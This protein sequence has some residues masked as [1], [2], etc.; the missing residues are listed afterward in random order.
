MSHDGL[1]PFLLDLQEISGGVIPVDRLMREALYHPDYGYYSKNIRTVGRRGDFATSASLGRI[2]GQA[3]AGWIQAQMALGMGN[4]VIEVGAGSGAMA[5]TV[6]DSLSFWNRLRVRYHIVESS[7]VLQEE[8]MI[9][10]RGRR[11]HW[12]D[13]LGEAL[14]AVSGR[15]IVFSNELIDAFPCRVFERRDG[16]WYEVAIRIDGGQLAEVLVT[17]D[18][19]PSASALEMD[20]PDT[21]RVEVHTAAGEWLASWAAHAKQVEMLTIDYGGLVD[22]LYHRR[23]RGTLRAYFHQQRFDGAAVFHRFGKQDITAD[24]NFSDLQSWGERLGWKTRK[25]QTQG[26]FIREFTRPDAWEKNPADSALAD[27]S[28]AGSAF[29]VLHQSMDQS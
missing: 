16:A 24:V 8:Q 27:L 29:Q 9:A 18:L 4:A 11:V 23:P 6:L 3:V 19:P 28:G 12:H 15:A 21:Q 7:P 25:L 13:S 17:A 14:H 2:L 22:S 20:F 5:S 1:I 26:A 10:L